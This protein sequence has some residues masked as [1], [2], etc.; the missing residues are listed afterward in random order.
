M[1]IHTWPDGKSFPCCLWDSGDP[2]GNINENTLEEIWNS[3]KMK[4]ARLKMIN[5]EEVESCKRCFHL[6][7][8][9]DNSYRQRI[10]SLHSSRFEE[11]KKTKEDGSLDEMKFYLWD[12]RLSNFCNFKCR[13]CGPELSSSWHSDTIK[14][15]YSKDQYPKPVININDRTSF[16]SMLEPHYQYVDEIYFAGGEPL[17]MPEHYLILDKLLELNR[18]DVNIRYSTNF[19]KLTYNK[20]HIFDYWKHFSN[21]E[22]YISIDGT[23]K[24]GEYVRKGYIDTEFHANMKSLID[25]NIKIKEFGFTVTYGV[26]NYLHLFDLVLD[27]LKR[28]YLDKGEPGP[29]RRTVLFNPIDTP[30][31]YDCSYLPDRYKETFSQRLSKFHLELSKSNCSKYFIEDMMRKF[32]S[33]QNKSQSK[34]FN[35][36]IMNKCVNMTERLDV[37]RQENFSS[38]FTY[39]S[40]FKA[41]ADNLNT[42]PNESSYN[43]RFTKSL[44]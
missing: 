41:L 2:V 5:G 31:Y 1:S 10:N 30:N 17:L 21:I 19:S 34:L 6:E 16:M 20:K 36:D 28:G 25:S 11:I 32:T 15:G 39:F 22:L 26:L 38:I 42:Y 40:G 12:V 23:G 29:G 18:T 27:F 35:K 9:G 13:S 7:S 3:Q 14:L 4:D 8:I 37:I 44:I 33:I 24:I 43:N